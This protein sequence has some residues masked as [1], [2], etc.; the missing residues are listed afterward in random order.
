MTGSLCSI[1]GLSFPI[2]SAK[3]LVSLTSYASPSPDSLE[4]GS[5]VLSRWDLGEAP[6]PILLSTNGNTEA[7]RN[8]ILQ[9]LFCFL[10]WFLDSLP[11]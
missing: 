3:K 5:E 8:K 6:S 1:I 9:S 4:S 2:C 7:Q 11:P 10:D